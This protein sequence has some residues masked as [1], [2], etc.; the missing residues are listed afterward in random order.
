[1]TKN[2]DI[3]LDTLQ[4]KH[5]ALMDMTIKNMNCE[6]IGLGIMDD[7]R[8]EQCE[9]LTKAIRMW[10]ASEHGLGL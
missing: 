9:Q 3:V 8:L 7:I 6:F 5:D 2:Y 1:M 10:K 4:A